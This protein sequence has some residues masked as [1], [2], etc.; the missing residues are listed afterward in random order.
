[1]TKTPIR[2]MK[3][4]VLAISLILMRPLPNTIAFGGVATGIINAHEA[5][6][7][8]GIMSIKGFILIATATEARIGRIISVVAVFEVSSV[9]KVRLK[10][11]IAVT[12]NGA[13]PAK[14]LNCLPIRE[15]S[16]VT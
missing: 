5:D 13:T 3:I 8:A 1:M 9:R 7:V 2:L 14:L 6:S 15:E 12:P 4:P 11:T 16:P 10:Q